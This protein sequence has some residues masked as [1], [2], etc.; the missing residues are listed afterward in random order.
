MSD[1][2]AQG[3]EPAVQPRF[4][5]PL[6]MPSLA[7][8]VAA[9]GAQRAAA[10]IKPD[11]RFDYRTQ[12]GESLG[13]YNLL[14]HC[15]TAWSIVDIAGQ[16]GGLDQQ[17]AAA[18]RA[19]GWLVKRRIEPLN[20][21]LCIASNGAAKLGGAGLG[22]LALTALARVGDRDQ[23][24]TTAEGLAR[25]ALSL[26][27]EDGDFHH[28]V[29][30]GT[31]DVLDFHSDYYT[32]EA[33]FGLVQV[34]RATLDEQYLTPVI[35]AIQALDRLDYGVKEQSHWMSYA[36]VALHAVTEETWLVDYAGRIIRNILDRPVYRRR[37]RSAPTACRVEAF[38]TYGDMLHRTGGETTGP[39]WDEVMENAALD[40]VALI[41]LR[42]PDGGFI[43]GYDDPAVQIDYI[44]HSASAFVGFH[45]N[46]M[47]AASG[48]N[49]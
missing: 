36:I 18:A 20:G 13:G 23:H 8:F 12:D 21:G 19:M 25:F 33:L 46:A 38:M 43:G 37:R 40:L 5:D 17:V 24:L 26:Q 30:T 47:R 3:H 42:L 7:G 49:G 35:R 27:R 4:R 11:G 39:R 45:R 2:K 1:D 14:R 9:T 48:L 44:Q 10:L 29:A 22:M 32:G 31:G 15:G 28:K 16:L 34:Y 41:G 6:A